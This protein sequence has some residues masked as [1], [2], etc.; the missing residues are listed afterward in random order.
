[1]F[2]LPD[3]FLFFL[4]LPF[5]HPHST[6]LR[7]K[8]VS[9]VLLL[10]VSLKHPVLELIASVR[11]RVFRRPSLHGGLHNHGR[12]G[13][14]IY[15]GAHSMDIACSKSSTQHSLQL[16]CS[17]SERVEW[18]DL[19][20]G[21]WKQRQWYGKVVLI[22]AVQETPTGTQPAV[23]MKLVLRLREGTTLYDEDCS[24]S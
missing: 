14:W 20:Q 13:N 18:Q 21:L 3:F 9:R 23:K 7:L 6:A 22:R 8:C 17:S 12:H 2:Y 11:P 16:C 24:L 19:F 5:L 10:G 15:P 4:L 1:M